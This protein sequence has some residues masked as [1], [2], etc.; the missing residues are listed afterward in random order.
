MINSNSK[1]YIDS[2][3]LDTFAVGMSL[4]CAIHCMIT[5]I[6]LT[7]LPVLATTLWVHRD[8]HLWM[9]ILVLPTT[10]T[11]IFLGCRK[12]K[13]RVVIALSFLGL[14]LLVGVAIYES[15]FHSGLTKEH[16]HCIHCTQRNYGYIFNS[17]TWI[18]LLGAA[19][20]TSG[21]IRNYWLC[22]KSKC[23]AS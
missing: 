3:W 6:V 8:F 7:L 10:A 23:C 2:G 11:A 9:L 5:P 20:L 1:K 19:F 15:F 21:H 16:M 12:H 18:N 22:R 17:S 4:M 13:D 14:T